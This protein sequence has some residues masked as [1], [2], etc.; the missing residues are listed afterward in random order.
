MTNS[1]T[2]EIDDLLIEVIKWAERHNY[3]ALRLSQ[4]TK[5]LIQNFCVTLARL[6]MCHT[7][8]DNGEIV[9]FTLTEPQFEQVTNLYKQMESSPESPFPDERQLTLPLQPAKVTEVMATKINSAFIEEN[10]GNDK[11]IKI[12]FPELNSNILITPRLLVQLPSACIRK[13]GKFFSATGRVRILDGILKSME[14]IM[15][16]KDLKLERIL[17]VLNLEDK[18]SPMFYIHLTDNILGKLK[19]EIKAAENIPIIQ[20]AMILKQFK[21]EQEEKEKDD[22]KS[23]LAQADIQKILNI[24]RGNPKAYYIEELYHFR[25]EEGRF[26][27]FSG[28]YERNEFILLVDQFI[29]TYTSVRENEEKLE[30]ATPQIIKLPDNES[31]DLFIYREYLVSLVER[32]RI[33][34]KND[35]YNTLL[36]K[37]IKALTNYLEL[38]EMRKDDSLE[39]EVIKIIEQKYKLLKF[40]ALEPL[41]LF[42][43]FKI[44]SDD[45]EINSKRSYYFSSKDKPTLQPFYAIMEIKRVDL[46]REAYSALPVMYRFFLTR[47]ILYI[48]SI[49][50]KNKSRGGEK[51]IVN[52]STGAEKSGTAEESDPSDTKKI[53]QSR[54]RKFL[55]EIEKTYRSS[56]N[57][58]DTLDQLVA[59]WNNKVG[60]VRTILKEKIDHDALERSTAIYKMMFKSPNFTQ[61]SLHREL[62]NMA[63]DLAQNKYTDIADKKS[64]ARY[65]ILTAIWNIRQKVR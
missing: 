6:N 9:A 58:Q 49:F 54:V 62:K 60:E 56:G 5:K 3:T 64:L 36:E 59:K 65:I 19:K 48:M 23:E 33:R 63:V 53:V 47:I 10:I 50:K 20:A 34:A 45:K 17:K 14:I 43:I 22:R 7:K 11:M 40:I 30:D 57:I 52:Q 21:L 38:P 29:E 12:L 55:P 51:N 15:P 1:A 25:E 24:F 18:E 39:S 46:Y 42:N 35:I 37:W 26:D 27:K 8:S 2:I 31:R 13:I 41:L 61:E 4:T 32:E 44:Y 16:E 28:T